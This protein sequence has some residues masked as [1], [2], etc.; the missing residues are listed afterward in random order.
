MEEIAT[1]M[2]E[3]GSRIGQLEENIVTERKKQV[4][5]ECI[6]NMD[7]PILQITVLCAIGH[8]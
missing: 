1:R 7:F 2:V 5:H 8:C 4:A 3:T 6:T